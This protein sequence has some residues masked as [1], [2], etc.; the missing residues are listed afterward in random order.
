MEDTGK[1][2][3]EKFI[4]DFSVDKDG[5]LR[6]VSKPYSCSQSDEERCAEQLAV[7]RKAVKSLKFLKFDPSLPPL[8]FKGKLVGDKFVQVPDDAA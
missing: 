6:L 3:D 8:P 7:A 4:T 2:S 5:Y 1:A